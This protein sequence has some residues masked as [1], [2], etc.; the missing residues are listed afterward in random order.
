[1][2]AYSAAVF[3]N[4]GNYKS[5]GDSKFVPEIEPEKFKKVAQSSDSYSTH[6]E[7]IENILG[8][9]ENDI[10]SEDEPNHIGFPDKNGQTSYYSSNVTSDEASKIDQFC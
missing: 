10:F 3:D 1:M 2:L 5:F 8:L 9:I 6:K 4:H 7:V